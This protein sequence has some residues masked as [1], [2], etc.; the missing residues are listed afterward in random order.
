MRFLKSIDV[1]SIA[2]F[3]TAVY[4]LLMTR[5]KLAPFARLAEATRSSASGQVGIE[6]RCLKEVF[7]GGGIQ[8][9]RF[10][11]GHRGAPRRISTRLQRSHDTGM[12][13]LALTDGKPYAVVRFL[14]PRKHPKWDGRKMLSTVIILAQYLRVSRR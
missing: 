8:N 6:N 9:L 1:S 3:G 7:G 2:A 13:R 10:Q 5:E 12:E 4:E 11:A 14:C